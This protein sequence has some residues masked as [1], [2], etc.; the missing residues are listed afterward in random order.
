MSNQNI[1][2]ESFD[3]KV[4]KMKKKDGTLVNVAYIDPQTSEN[5]FE[6]KDKLKNDFGAFWDSY[7]KR[8]FW[9]LSNDK[10]K[11]D[12]IIANKI[13]PAIDFLVSVE[14]PSEGEENRV[15][16]QV[17]DAIKKLIDSIDQ[18]IAAPVSKE[19]DKNVAMSSSEL[20]A[21][22]EEYKK[23][24]IN[25]L[26]DAEFKKKLEPLI[27]FRNAQG[28][29]FSFINTILV[30]L[31]D[32]NA[33]L[34]K[35][36]GRWLPFNREVIPGSPAI[37]LFVPVGGYA[38]SKDEKAS[39]TQKFLDAF[40]KKDV[41]E[42]N[43]GEKEKL[44]VALKPKGSGRFEIINKFYD[45]RHTRVI[46]GKED[47]AGDPDAD[48]EWFDGTS[49]ETKETKKLYEAVIAVVQ[50]SGI[51]IKY[52]ADLG[53]ARG[54]STSGVIELLTNVPKNAGTVSTVVHEFSHELLHQ[55]YLKNEGKEYADFFIGT[56][57][58]RSVV[59]QQAELSAWIVL[60]SFGINLQSSINYTAIWGIDE[61]NA[62]KVFDTVARVATFIISKMKQKLDSLSEG[63]KYITEITGWDVAKLCGPEAEKVYK[64]SFD[65]QN[66]EKAIAEEEI[67]E[68]KKLMKKL[69][70][71]YLLF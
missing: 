11:N 24:L 55:Q 39:I 43:P 46:N 28:H 10:S 13:N 8:W 9:Y 4:G 33:K 56:K 17:Q 59:E 19:G 36:A 7:N 27:K 71:T 49:K 41:S 42:L 47:L 45:I 32:P 60:R 51:R 50:E 1:L 53:G 3:F 6:Y 40:G 68:I 70:H 48:I 38:L 2:K 66:D 63:K 14:T 23:D 16:S 67:N 29:Q 22:L 61:K 58:G 34:V 30:M 64:R 20:K 25:T 21:E 52:V 18:V 37:G 65:L 15:S 5:T 31:Q 69:D 26:N 35:A 12:W 62:T 44:T 54:V 57:Q